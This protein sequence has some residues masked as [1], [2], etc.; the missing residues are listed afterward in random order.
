MR[1][2][3]YLGIPTTAEARKLIQKYYLGK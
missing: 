1:K 2:P 3:L